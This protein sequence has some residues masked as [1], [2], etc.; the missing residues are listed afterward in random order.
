MNN[1]FNLNRIELQQFVTYDV[2]P[3]EKLDKKFDEVTPD[4]VKLF[5]MKWNRIT[6]CISS[7]MTELD[8]KANTKKLILKSIA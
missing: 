5:G 1:I 2:I 4:V 8:S 6:D 7:P 3:Q